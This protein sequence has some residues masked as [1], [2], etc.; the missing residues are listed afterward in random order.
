MSV[1]ERSAIN[2][3][4]SVPDILGE[5]T[6]FRVL[7]N[8]F[9]KK[10]VSEGKWFGFCTRVD[11]SQYNIM[12]IKNADGDSFGSII[13]EEYPDLEYKPAVFRSFMRDYLCY[14]EKPTITK[15]RSGATGFRSS[16]DKSLV[17]SSLT[18][19]S[20]WLSIS[21]EQ[22]KLE[23]GYKFEN[24]LDDNPMIPYYRL[25]IGRDG[26]HKV[27]KPRKDLDVRE[28]G[29]RICPLFALRTGVNLLYKMLCQ[30]SYNVEFIKDGGQK[31]TINCT[32]NTKLLSSVYKPEFI[33][34]AAESWYDGSFMLNPYMEK[35]YIKVFEFGGSIYDNPTRSIN[36]ARITGFEKA[37][38]DLTFINIDIDSVVPEFIR[39]V[40]NSRIINIDITDFVNTLD[41]F[42]VGSSR[43]Y[44]GIRLN[45][46][47]S[48]TQWATSQY[49]LL[50]TVFARQLSLFMIGN[51]QWFE[52]YTG[53]PMKVSTEVA[54]DESELSLDDFDFELV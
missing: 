1:L 14:C 46:V 52:G 49:A 48:V 17:T 21:M 40:E 38:P 29:V 3:M 28:K 25:Y 30:D 26:T 51:P 19:I 32:F 43:E 39:R 37:E 10:I 36:Y 8:K 16:F 12:S 50:S 34:S 31:R 18:V 22:T 5:N 2:E 13:S 20:K 45:N 27:S 54:T 42:E 6:K 23:Y 47:A 4:V 53:E 41:I 35:G 33:A 9:V 24:L 7:C 44:G 15:D 11:D